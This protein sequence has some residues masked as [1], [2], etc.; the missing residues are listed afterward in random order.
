VDAS[1]AIDLQLVLFQLFFM[2][3]G[4]TAGVRVF[5]DVKRWH[6]ARVRSSESVDV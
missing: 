4:L 2:V 6:E 1:G 3:V 5:D